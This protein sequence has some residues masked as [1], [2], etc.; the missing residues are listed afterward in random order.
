MQSWAKD[1]IL[2]A[3][4]WIVSSLFLLLLFVF[5]FRFFFFLKKE[6]V[7]FI[8]VENIL[9]KLFSSLILMFIST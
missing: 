2:K 4:S 8:E 3:Y 1:F 7:I 9:I 6:L 5:L